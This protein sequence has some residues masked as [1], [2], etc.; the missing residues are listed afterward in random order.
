MLALGGAALGIPLAAWTMK[1]FIS[2]NLQDLPRIQSAT[3][4]G[5]VLGFVFGITLLTS[6]FFG[7]VPALRSSSP[8]LIE[9]MKEGRSTTATKKHQRLRSILVV[10]ETALGLMLLVTAGLLLRSFH[11][12]TQVDPGF[13]AASILSFNFDLPDAKYDEAK[14]VQFYQDLLPRLHALPG[15]TTASGITPLP[16]SGNNYSISFQIEGR[17]VPKADEPSAA[18]R[19]ASPGYFQTMGIPMLNG[20]DFTPRDVDNS[21]RVTIINE[22]FARRF[23]PNENQSVSESSPECGGTE[24]MSHAR[25]WELWETS[26]TIR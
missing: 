6:L 12:L 16:F 25:L 8:N 17:P 3:I 2:M 20:R 22:A 19:V 10:A 14:Q 24:N 4:D 23:F 13:N 15:V 26:G 18:F 1:L 21:P 11:K 7:L 9:F 5:T